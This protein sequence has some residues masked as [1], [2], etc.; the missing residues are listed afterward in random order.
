LADVPEVQALMTDGAVSAGG[1][2]E[3]ARCI[4]T[5][6]THPYVTIGDIDRA[7]AVLAAVSA[8][9]LGEDH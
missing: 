9:R 3:V 4:V 6:P 8:E 5:L 2:R 7:V 1:G